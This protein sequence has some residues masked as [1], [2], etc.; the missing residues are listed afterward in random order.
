[1]AFP[2]PPDLRAYVE[3]R[4][5]AVDV[6]AGISRER[7]HQ[8]R[9]LHTLITELTELGNPDN[10]KHARCDT[11]RLVA[12]AIYTAE[13]MATNP[14]HVNGVAQPM[15]VL[16]PV[17]RAPPHA[18]L[19]SPRMMTLGLLLSEML[20]RQTEPLAEMQLRSLVQMNGHSPLELSIHEVK[21]GMVE[22]L[23]RIQAACGPVTA[24]K[25]EGVDLPVAYVLEC[26]G[27]CPELLSLSFSGSFTENVTLFEQIAWPKKLE[28]VNLSK[29]TVLPQHVAKMLSECPA[30]KRLNVKSCER[31]G[32]DEMLQLGFSNLFEELE[33]DPLSVDNLDDEDY[34]ERVVELLKN[35]KAH[36][37]VLCAVAETILEQPGG[38]PA[39]AKELL[40]EAIKLAPR[41]LRAR[42]VLAELLRTGNK[43]IEVDCPA[44]MHLLKEAL[45][46]SAQHPRSLAA[47]ARLYHVQGDTQRAKEWATLAFKLASEDD[48]CIASYAMTLLPNKV[49][50]GAMAERAR[51]INPNNFYAISVL[52]K[53]EENVGNLIDLAFDLNPSNSSIVEMYTE[54]LLES[55]KAENRASAREILQK[56][57]TRM[58]HLSFPS[59]FLAKIAMK[60][61]Q[62]AQALAELNAGYAVE[63]TNVKILEEMAE[64]FRVGKGEISQDYVQ[65]KNIFE[66]ILALDKKNI[67]ALS[68]LGTLYLDEESGELFNPTNGQLLLLEAYKIDEDDS[69]ISSQYGASLLRNDN[70]TIYDPETGIKLLEEAIREDS[71]EVDA[72]I[73]LADFYSREN[74][75]T[76]FH[77]PEAEKRYLEVLKIDAANLSALLGLSRLY[78]KIG[79]RKRAMEHVERLLKLDDNHVDAQIVKGALLLQLDRVKNLEQVQALL[80]KL[81]GPKLLPIQRHDIKT[82]ILMYPEMFGPKRQEI[83]RTLS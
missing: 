36:P 23:K 21:N 33:Y 31:L 32:F 3:G 55:E 78:L 68:G 25:I 82:L 34:K 56:F 41:T 72:R 39:K 4:A 79:E 57:R 65:A 75:G 44:A 29:T 71:Q 52:L 7:P 67:I 17:N 66:A 9:Q 45:Q 2:P 26:V 13:H 5:T 58:P 27:A 83:L 14:Q 38:E 60:E 54:P 28:A 76:Y 47:A 1:M 24:L 51:K 81:I 20:S 6:L 69:F 48:F 62:Y 80:Q 8:K 49:I 18:P 16:P 35:L 50:A 37:V 30:L 74:V 22:S 42:A 15:L 53:T 63:P 59:L 43:G 73:H 10:Q 19:L 46:I 64:I 61:E 70:Q 11:L 12:E 77:P 40:L